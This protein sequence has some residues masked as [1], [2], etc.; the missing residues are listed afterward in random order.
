MS[1]ESSDDDSP[2]RAV[3]AQNT[4][5]GLISDSDEYSDSIPPPP[6]VSIVPAPPPS[7]PP[8]ATKRPRKPEEDDEAEYLELMKQSHPTKPDVKVSP[9]RKL[10]FNF[11]KELIDRFSDN[12]FLDCTILPRTAPTSKFIVRRKSWPINVQLSF[13]SVESGNNSFAIELTEYG[14][15]S[16]AQFDRL[17]ETRNIDAMVRMLMREPFNV[18]LLMGIGR[19]KLFLKE[20]TDATDYALKLTFL[21]QQTIPGAFVFGS[22]KFSAPKEFFEMVGFI[23]RF[24]F[25]RGC[26]TTSNE[27]WKFAA[28][29]SD[30]ADP[31]GVLLAAAVP[32]FYAEDLDFLVGMLHSPVTFR[33]IPLNSIPDWTVCEALLAEDPEKVAIEIAKW[34]YVFGLGEPGDECPMALQSLQIA[35]RRR[36][37]PILEKDKAKKV[38]RPAQEKLDALNSEELR[39][40]VYEKWE[41][42]PP[43]ESLF[44]MLVEEDALPVNPGA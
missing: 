28:L 36:I 41:F 3:P 25:R 15:Q 26:F 8:R 12:S 40:N 13:R 4:F 37:L 24:A 34:P 20:F 7:A 32:A 42:F 2:P 33:E 43:E 29:N 5:A 39:R 35:L 16:K 21:L 17:Q 27:L 10:Q 30:D 14:Q 22:W 31:A 6:P 18:W 19:L 23:A 38:I 44:A 9:Q 1:T 11:A